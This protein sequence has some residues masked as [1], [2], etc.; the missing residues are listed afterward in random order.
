MSPAPT[1][2]RAEASDVATAV[3][4]GGDDT[5]SGKSWEA[6]FYGSG[7]EPPQGPLRW[8]LTHWDSGQR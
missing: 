2:T 7:V 4:D 6:F 8:F 3:Y 5:S 1:P